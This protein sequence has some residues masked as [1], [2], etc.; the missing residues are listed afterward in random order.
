MYE[1]DL[2]NVYSTNTGRSGILISTIFFFK[3]GCATRNYE[4]PDFVRNF[5]LPLC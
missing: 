4:P 5:L 2:Q 3:S 1:N